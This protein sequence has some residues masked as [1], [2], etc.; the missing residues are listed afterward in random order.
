MLRVIK[1]KRMRW[2]GHIVCIRKLRYVY[3]IVVGKHYLGDFSI[4]G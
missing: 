2:T 1:S 3:R 4:D